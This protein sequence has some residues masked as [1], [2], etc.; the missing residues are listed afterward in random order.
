LALALAGVSSG[1]WFL[2][3]AGGYVVCR[4]ALRPVT[5]MACAARE[6]Q[7]VD[8][9]R[10]LPLAHTGDQLDDLRR[11]FTSLLDRVQDGCERQKRFPGEAS[12]QRATPLTGLL[13]QLE[14]A[15]RRE[16]SPEEYRRALATAHQQGEQMRRLVEALLFLARA[17]VEA[18]IPERER[19]DMREWLASH[20][21]KWSTHDR[22]GDISLD[23]GGERVWV[24]THPI[25]LG[26]LVNVLLDNACKH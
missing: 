10:R 24:E 15:L 7:A 13:G 12:R 9:A 3:L 25:L 19:L 4:R 6:M 22:A 5:R 8:I 23:A 21:R 2:A 26:E 14:V 16:R 11:S 20:Y 17:D 18:R 1:V